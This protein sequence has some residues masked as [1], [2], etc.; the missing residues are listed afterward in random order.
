MWHS[1]PYLQLSRLAPQT[2]L[3]R[4]SLFLLWMP[5]DE[6]DALQQEIAV[7]Q[8]SLA[9]RRAGKAVG[10]SAVSQQQQPQQ[11]RKP[12]AVSAPWTKAAA[13]PQQ[14]Q[15]R[16]ANASATPPWVARQQQGEDWNC[17]MRH[18]SWH[19]S[20]FRCGASQPCAVEAPAAKR[21]KTVASARVVPPPA[22]I[23]ED[24]GDAMHDVLG[25]L[26][27]DDLL[28]AVVVKEKVLGPSFLAIWE[29]LSTLPKSETPTANAAALILALEGQLVTAA[30]EV[31]AVQAF[32]VEVQ[33]AAQNRADLLKKQL[34]EAKLKSGA[35]AAPL[36]FAA[37]DK[38]RADLVAAA[39]AWASRAST[40]RQ[41]VLL[42]IEEV[43]RLA[44]VAVDTIHAQLA[45]LDTQTQV[46]EDHWTEIN[47]RVE[48]DFAARVATLQQHCDRLRLAE[49]IVTPDPSAV[50]PQVMS[51]DS[52]SEME[53]LRQQMIALS[54][55]MQKQ[56]EDHTAQLRAAAVMHDS[57][58][59]QWKLH[60][61]GISA[62]SSL[63]RASLPP[64]A[65][66]MNQEE[67]QQR[68]AHA[69]SAKGAALTAV[70]DTAPSGAVKA[71]QV[72]D[73]AGANY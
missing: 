37:A 54:S 53:K 2:H 71:A 1:G 68:L 65:E 51:T 27:L 4:Y 19:S 33:T 30:A 57:K 31:T 44:K 17:C 66:A 63:L 45:A 38:K 39:Q 59:E 43:E 26:A 62:E 34:E 47:A 42:E 29:K 18:S 15:Q 46:H 6:E 8:R 28:D 58:M 24:T 10:A 35:E 16:V 21:A 70:A 69:D 12:Q 5:W 48:E 11:S 14:Q 23:M 25:E 64:A 55:Q 3:S 41:A 67:T 52:V 72:V 61:D 40:K 50:T 7:L 60:C 9:A 56:A 36:T 73:G 49:G 13:L 32:S 22:A 20:C